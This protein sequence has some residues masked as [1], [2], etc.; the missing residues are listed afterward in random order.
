MGRGDRIKKWFVDLKQTFTNHP[1][2]LGQS[3][4]QHFAG[5]IQIAG[6]HFWHGIMHLV[7][8]CFP[9]CFDHLDTPSSNTQSVHQV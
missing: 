2:A 9:F 6:H 5:S 4:S 8:G 3:F 1:E 7:H